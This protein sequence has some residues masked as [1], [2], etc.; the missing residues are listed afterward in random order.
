[1]VVEA[2]DLLGEEA[3]Y[4]GAVVGPHWEQTLQPEEVSLGLNLGWAILIVRLRMNA[5]ICG[6]DLTPIL[7]GFLS[8]CFRIFST[9]DWACRASSSKDFETGNVPP[10]ATC[11]KPIMSA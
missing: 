9:L 11:A 7:S 1:M 2:R 4:Q 3:R 10:A 8:A 5:V 6:L